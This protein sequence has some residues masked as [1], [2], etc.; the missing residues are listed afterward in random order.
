VQ[1]DIPCS[2]IDIVVSV[3]GMEEHEIR[4]FVGSN[5]FR[6]V[7]YMLRYWAIELLTALHQISA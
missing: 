4:S 3:D 1:V 7:R 5:A 2:L 6:N